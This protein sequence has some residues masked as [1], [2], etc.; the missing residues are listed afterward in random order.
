MQEGVTKRIVCEEF[1]PTFHELLENEDNAD[2][3]LTKMSKNCQNIWTSFRRVKADIL[4]HKKSSTNI[5]I[6]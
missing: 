2:T 4:S 1:E 5:D 3:A 6:L